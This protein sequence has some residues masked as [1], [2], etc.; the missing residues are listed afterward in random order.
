MNDLDLRRSEIEECVQEYIRRDVLWKPDILLIKKDAT[1][2]IVKD[3]AY[4]PF[5]FRF[6]VGTFANFRE[7]RTYRKLKGLHG[8]P[9]VYGQVDRY[10][11][12]LAYIP[13]RNTGIIHRGE[14]DD[15]FFFRLQKIV[16][17]IHAHGFVLCDLR[18]GKN[19]MVGEENEPYVIDLCTAFERGGRFN[20]LRNFLFD[21]FRQ[22]DL[23]GITKL[24]TKL[25]PHLVGPDEKTKL[26]RGLIFQ[27]QAIW[28]RNIARRFL[29]KIGKIGGFSGRN[30]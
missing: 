24:K 25:A 28:V 14:L 29:K 16:D 18:N 20:I 9:K 2:A 11:L 15:G 12:V 19:I 17:E 26:E 13:G 5:L 23:L 30:H 6:F 21:V 3:Y 8:I 27:R 1:L 7:I 4:Q 22:D 10:A